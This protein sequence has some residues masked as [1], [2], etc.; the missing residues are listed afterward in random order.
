MTLRVLIAGAGDV[1]V[2]LGLRLATLGHDVFALRRDPSSIPAPLIGIAADLSRPESLSEL[3]TG[4]T[5]VAYTAAA[6]ASTDEAYQRAYVN[7]LAN[8]LGHWQHRGET[9][10]RVVFVS[11]TAV[12]AQDDGSAVDEH[13]ATEPTHFSG[14][15]TLE[16]ERLLLESNVPATVLRCGGIYGPG[17]TQ[18]LDSV[19]EG[20]AT[21]DTAI[22]RYT[23]RIHVDDV[24]GALEFLLLHPDP[25]SVVLGVDEEPAL[26]REVLEWL[27]QQLGAPAP[28]AGNGA[29]TS[30]RRM[31][32][33]KRISSERLRALGYRF[34]YPTYREGYAALIVPKAPPPSGSAT[35]R[36]GRGSCG[37][38]P[39]VR[40]GS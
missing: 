19:R 10:Q 38:V 20:R 39:C 33:N 23:N 17:R 1:G 8:L 9:L 25:P 32:S 4:L 35:A 14:L 16:A 29:S 2:R 12:H 31:A 30:P 6:D 36:S 11:S 34:R 27:A 26:Q 3:P 15:R 24:A 22:P 5:H 40:R 37:S 21:F 28:R 13:S 7:G 18:L